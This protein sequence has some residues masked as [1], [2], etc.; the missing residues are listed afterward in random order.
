M[1]DVMSTRHGGRE[2][3]EVNGTYV[4]PKGVTMRFF[5]NDHTVMYA[6]ASDAILDFLCDS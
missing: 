4:V 5:T 2:D 1:V 3:G 6:G